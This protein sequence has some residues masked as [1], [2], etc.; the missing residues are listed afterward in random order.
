MKSVFP[1]QAR[2]RNDDNKKKRFVIDYNTG[3]WKVRSDELSRTDRCLTGLETAC[4]NSFP[5]I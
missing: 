5:V 3:C 2:S 4:C 1:A